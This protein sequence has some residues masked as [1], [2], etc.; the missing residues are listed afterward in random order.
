MYADPA[1]HKAYK[2]VTPGNCRHT[3]TE[4]RCVTTDRIL[5]YN[6]NIN[7]NFSGKPALASCPLDSQVSN[8]PYPEH[9]H[10]TGQK[11]SY[12]VPTWYFRLYPHTYIK[13]HPFYQI[14][15]TLCSA[16]SS[17][18]MWNSLNAGPTY[19]LNKIN[20]VKP[21]WWGFV[22]RWELRRED[23]STSVDTAAESW[24]LLE[25]LD[26]AQQTGPSSA[27]CVDHSEDCWDLWR[28]IHTDH[29]HVHTIDYCNKKW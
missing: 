17:P 3:A 19:L 6:H 12:P 2:I 13:C 22:S 16:V 20:H 24:V 11:S 23:P 25:L 15:I 18:K 26:T 4:C 29:L 7:S 5:C 10:R 21:G 8:H 27:A 28:Y 1:E 14:L 9:T